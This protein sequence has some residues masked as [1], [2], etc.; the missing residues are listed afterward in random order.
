MTDK[1]QQE[2]TEPR[3]TWH[4]AFFDAI[5]LVLEGYHD[6]LQFIF[7]HSLTDEPLR[8]DAIIIKDPHIEIDKDIGRIFRQ[9]NIAEYKSPDDSL[10]I[11]DFHKVLSY[12]HLYASPN[13]G[14]ITDMTISFVVSRYPREMIKRLQQV[15]HYHI[16]KQCEGIYY[17]SG[18]L[19]PIQIVVSPRL[20]EDD[21]LWLKHLS[22]KLNIEG[23][24]KIIEAS[25]EKAER[26]YIRAYMHQLFQANPELLK[27]IMNMQ[28]LTVKQ[29]LEEAGWTAEWEARGEVQG[30]EKRAIKI[31][32]NL[33]PLG[34]SIEQIAKAAEL[35]IDKVKE[36]CADMQ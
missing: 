12:A 24:N 6:W 25:K 27:E 22:N 2:H 11:M 4:T 21:N 35:D 32:R 26:A 15:Y 7:E 19:I 28:R 36:L 3:I 16:S 17:V 1:P 30:E 34:L 8:V 23:M 5:R 33:I 31:A 14:H 10:T 9:Y 29:I 13:K 18:E 20:P